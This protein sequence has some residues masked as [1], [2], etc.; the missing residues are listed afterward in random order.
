M[1][2]NQ[3]P[4]FSRLFRAAETDRV[5]TVDV[6]AV[7]RRA[8]RRRIPK[9]IGLGAGVALAA[10]VFVGSGVI[11][12]HTLGTTTSAGSASSAST[13]GIA[14]E[15]NPA[16]D[17][18]SA[19][20]GRCGSPPAGLTPTP[21]GLVATVAIPDAKA[22]QNVVDGTVTLTN[23]GPRPVHATAGAP[24]VDLVRNGI[25]A[26][27]SDRT[28]VGSTGEITLDPGTSTRFPIE[29][30]T[31]LCRA[32]EDKSGALPA[33]LPAAP[34][35]AYQVFASIELRIDGTSEFV[36]GPGSSFRIR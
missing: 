31:Q 23:T 16:K 19:E 20:S 32:S 1:V 6:D 36:N 30:R 24:M 7:I 18:G 15:A 13:A 4:D 28:A 21:N 11:G 10:V 3:E 25:I 35:G 29:L 22:G 9:L 27:H 34:S 17:F 8:R 5:G 33:D 2:D 12:L 14:P 26:W